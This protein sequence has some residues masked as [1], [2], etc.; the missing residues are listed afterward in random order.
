MSHTHTHTRTHTHKN[1][2]TRAHAC[3]CVCVCVIV[4][5]WM[6][7]YKFY[8]Q[9][10]GIIIFGNPFLWSFL[11]QISCHYYK[12]LHL[13]LCNICAFG[14]VHYG[15]FGKYT[16][17]Y[18]WM[19]TLCD[20]LPIYLSASLSPCVS[21]VSYPTSAFTMLI[22]S[23]YIITNTLYHILPP[24]TEIQFCPTPHPYYVSFI[25]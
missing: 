24:T 6:H 12:G 22:Y 8:D 17:T 9:W 25:I 23:L 4:F 1:T 21:L 3:L 18:A 2:R 11:Q 10:D 20:H 5:C 19:S 15:K 7:I 16:K 13:S 14:N